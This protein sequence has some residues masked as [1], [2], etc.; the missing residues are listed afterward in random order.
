LGDKINIYKQ[1]YE[2]N[3]KCSIDASMSY[4]NKTRPYKKQI[5]KDF[6]IIID[7]NP[8]NLILELKIMPK[9]KYFKN[10]IYII[11]VL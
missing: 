1:E 7:I 4:D 6:I 11:S 9:K 2:A 5:N 3:K 8:D 10:I